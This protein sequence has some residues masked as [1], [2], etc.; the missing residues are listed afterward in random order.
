MVNTWELD[1]VAVVI[2]DMERKPSSITLGLA[3]R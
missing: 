3:W 2:R 1:H